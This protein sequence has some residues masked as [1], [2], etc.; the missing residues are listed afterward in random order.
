MHGSHIHE[1][2]I[3]R[4]VLPK[5]QAQRKTRRIQCEVHAHLVLYKNMLY[6]AAPGTL[7][8]GAG[9]GTMPTRGGGTQGGVLSPETPFISLLA[10]KP[11]APGWPGKSL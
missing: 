2:L 8:G 9:H 1:T 4:T 7:Y 10:R 5:L 11:F 3:S 6:N